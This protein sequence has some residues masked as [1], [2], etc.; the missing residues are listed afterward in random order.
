[1]PADVRPW[2]GDEA[3]VALLAGAGRPQPLLVAAVRDRERAEA[4]LERLGAAPSGRHNG[5]ALLRLP[6]PALAAFAGDHLVIG[7]EAAVRGAV[8]RAADEVR[9]PSP[10]AASS[11]APPRSASRPRAS[12]R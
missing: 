5:A 4:M 8:D 10:T 12:T 11:G 7:P 1:V 3:A 2:L 6:P 9:P